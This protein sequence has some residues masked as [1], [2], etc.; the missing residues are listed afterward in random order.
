M[1]KTNQTKEKSYV[2]ASLGRCGSTL[3]TDCIY[4]HISTGIKDDHRQKRVF[5]E[6]Y[7]KEFKK[8]YVYKTHLYPIDF[9]ENCKVIFTFGDPLDII[10]SV[11]RKSKKTHWKEAHF[12]N[13][14]ANK[15]DLPKIMF[16]DVLGLER[17]FDAFYKAQSFDLLCIRY[18]T[19]WENEDKISDFLGFKI[20]LPKK[21]ARKTFPSKHDKS[22]IQAFKSSYESLI[23]K[24]EQAEDIKR[25]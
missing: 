4:K 7:P 17:M 15:E 9:P 10:L 1:S 16:E 13:M 3:I 14:G 21:T 19:M 25:W 23:T 5:L 8:G 11:V 24:I 18:E 2:V 22:K 12:K 6:K 20:R